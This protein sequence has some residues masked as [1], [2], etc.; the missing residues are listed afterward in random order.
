MQQQMT[1]GGHDETMPTL[2]A[3]NNLHID[4]VNYTMIL[5]FKITTKRS[6]AEEEMKLY[7]ESVGCATF[8]VAHAV[9]PG[10]SD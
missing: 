9:Q 5:K 7:F 6:S 10:R 2:R 3:F 8:F 4:Y 1:I